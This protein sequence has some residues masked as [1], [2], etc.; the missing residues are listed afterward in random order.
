MQPRH[1]FRA[2]PLVDAKA[3]FVEVS[4]DDVVATVFYGPVPAI[5]GQYL[6]WIGLS[7]RLTGDAQCVLDGAHTA[8][9]VH[10][11]MLDQKDL[12]HVG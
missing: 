11:I 7:V 6:F 9:L 2:V 1:I 3:I 5:G 10:D 4:I 12:P 8:F